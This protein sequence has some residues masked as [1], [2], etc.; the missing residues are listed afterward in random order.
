MKIYSAIA[1]SAA[2]L[3]AA[4]LVT[5]QAPAPQNGAPAGPGRGAAGR[6]GPPTFP[7]RPPADPALVAKGSQLFGVNCSFCHGS[8]ARGGEGGPN[9][10]RDSLVMDD[11]NGELITKVVQ[12]GI[13]DKGMPKFDA[14][15]QADIV[16]I[17]AW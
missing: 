13:P 1:I 4:V 8:D 15:S 7:E 6:G 5:A 2:L 3:G 14:L 17:A 12:T 11:R 9:L 16:A 10:L